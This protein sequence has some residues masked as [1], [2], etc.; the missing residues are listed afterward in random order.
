MHG[1]KE[2]DLGDQG[3]RWGEA[4]RRGC[5]DIRIHSMYRIYLHEKV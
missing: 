5:R 2:T 4:K 1:K 3:D